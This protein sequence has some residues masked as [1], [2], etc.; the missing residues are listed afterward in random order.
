[1]LVIS[2]RGFCTEHKENTLNA[3]QAAIA[4]GV[5]GIETDVRLSADRLPVLCHDRVTPDGREVALLTRDELAE[6]LGHPVPT[7]DEALDIWAA[8]LWNVEIKTP[9]ALNAVLEVLDG[10]A[11]SR[12]V[13]IT[14]FWHDLIKC[15]ASDRRFGYGV[16]LANRPANDQALAAILDSVP[17]V[18]S[19]VWD[20][21]IL[22]PL[23]L[24]QLHGRNVKIFAY[25]PKSKKEHDDCR[26]LKLDGVITDH[27]GYL[28][29]KG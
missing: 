13:L 7:L 11:S 4:L 10:Y 15:A 23:L 14:S 16:L 12:N 21:E 8:G 24:R 26:S 3:F 18:Q 20:F 25:G 28:L 17:W 27:P 1:M 2:H 29:P 19:T 22:D 5:D 9:S 6:S